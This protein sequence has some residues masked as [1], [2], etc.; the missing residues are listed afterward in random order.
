[1]LEH[2][3]EE[4]RVAVEKEATLAVTQD[5]Q[6]TRRLTVDV[7]HAARLRGGGPVGEH[8]RQGARERRVRLAQESASSGGEDTAALQAEWRRTRVRVTFEARGTRERR[9]RWARTTL[10]S[11]RRF[12]E[13]VA[14]AAALIDSHAIPF[15][16]QCNVIEHSVRAEE[17]CRATESGCR[18]AIGSIART[19]RLSDRAPTYTSAKARA[20]IS[21]VPQAGR[22]PEDERGDYYPRN[23]LTST[24]S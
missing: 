19:Q 1:M 2:Q 7:G 17:S 10:R 5:L 12:G 24:S 21:P 14:L 18:R 6:S 11:T 23:I 20:T 22:P 16:S 4:C 15:A 3:R 9:V 13:A 8:R